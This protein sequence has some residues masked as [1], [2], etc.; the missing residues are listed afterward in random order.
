MLISIGLAVM[1][2]YCGTLLLFAAAVAEAQQVSTPA[3]NVQ[4]PFL[5]VPPAVSDEFRFASEFPEFE[6]K[7]I[8]SR[9]WRSEDLRG[10]FTLIYIWNTFEARTMD[11]FDP[12][13]RYP[14]AGLPDLPQLERFYEKSGTAKNIQVLT[15]CVDYDYMRAHDYMKEKKYTF[16]VI[17]D[18]ALANKL[19]PADTCRQ[20]CSYGLPSPTGGKAL[21]SRQWV[22]NPEGRLS[23][24]FHAWSFG[25]LLFALEAV[26]TN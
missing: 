4:S 8:S 18:W 25:H 12:H 24:P 1:L 5:S 20:G 10:K 22:I 9:T 17:A 3:P 21:A 11:Q 14:D 23:Y 15:F 2:V 19:F 6:A 16:P 7:D 13:S 26:A